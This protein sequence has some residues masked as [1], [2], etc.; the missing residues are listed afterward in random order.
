MLLLQHLDRFSRPW[1]LL[2][3]LDLFTIAIGIS[4]VVGH[5][6]HAASERASVPALQFSLILAYLAALRFKRVC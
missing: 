2:L 5:A 3:L 1:R 4:N 6:L